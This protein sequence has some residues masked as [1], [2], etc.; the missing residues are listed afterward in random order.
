MRLCRYSIYQ[1]PGKPAFRR[2]R[3]HPLA[4]LQALTRELLPEQ[5]GAAFSFKKRLSRGS[6][7]RSKYFYI[8]FACLMRSLSEIQ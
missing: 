1:V 5:A 4:I 3:C 2:K 7:R 8:T 6:M